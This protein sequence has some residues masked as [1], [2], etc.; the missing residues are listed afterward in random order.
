MRSINF[1]LTYLLTYTRDKKNEKVRQVFRERSSGPRSS[2]ALRAVYAWENIDRQ[3]YAGGKI[4]ACS[5]VLPLTLPNTDRIPKLFHGDLAV[6][7]Y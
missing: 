7:L 2:G 3:F 5:L 4:S 6:N 1:I